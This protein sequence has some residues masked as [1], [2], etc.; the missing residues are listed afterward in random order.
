MGCMSKEGGVSIVMEGPFKGACTCSATQMYMQRHTE[1]RCDYLLLAID[2]IF[3]TPLCLDSRMLS[4][5][6]ARREAR[7]LAVQLARSPLASG[8][9]PCFW[10]REG[11]RDKQG[12]ACY[13]V[14]MKQKGQS[15]PPMVRNLFECRM[16]DAW[17]PG[18]S[19]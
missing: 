2:D 9:S 5:V 10:M 6:R 16:L 15:L 11:W 19:G 4:L 8:W 7:L 13:M 1:S 14:M 17:W 3:L 12:V 18:H